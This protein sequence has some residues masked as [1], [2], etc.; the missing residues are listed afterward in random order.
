MSILFKKVLIIGML[1]IISLTSMGMEFND[2]EN[3]F[4]KNGPRDK[5]IIAL[6]FDDGPHPRETDE[7][8]DVL[9]KYDVKGTFFIA[10]KHAKWYPESLLKAS[11]ENHE[12]GN[13]TFTHPDISSLNKEQIKQ[14][15]LGCEEIIMDLTGVKTNLFRP[16]YGS[17]RKSELAEIADEL[18]YKIVLWTTLDTKDWE[19]PPAQKIADLVIDKAKNGDIILLHDYGTNNTVE[20]LDI[21]IPKMIEKGFEFVTVSELIQE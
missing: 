4:I 14:E 1:V 8:L 17:Y 19:N 16:P 7:I 12:I 9:R 6:T 13:H 15:I 18:G 2:N 3:K 10:G 5:P 21:L 20:A 11:K